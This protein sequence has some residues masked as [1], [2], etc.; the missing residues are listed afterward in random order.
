MFSRYIETMYPEDVNNDYPSL[1]CKHLFDSFLKSYSG[2]KVN[3]L[4]IGSGRGTHL[5]NF[6]SH[7]EGNF[8]G[9][10][11]EKTEIPG[12]SIQS[13]NLEND[14]LPYDDGFFD[15]VFSKSVIEHVKNTDNFMKEI[16]RVLKPGG[17]LILMAPDWQ[18][19]MKNFYDD[20]THVRPFT[21]KSFE[22]LLNVYNFDNAQVLLFRQLPA[23]WK[24]PALEYFCDIIAFVFPESFKWKSSTGRNTNDRKIIRFSK[25]KMLIGV[26][27]K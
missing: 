23:V 18:S 6:R 24:Y 15:I 8:H 2:K 22:S 21:K 12:A 16:Y 17:I 10:D 25:E 4:D 9:I 11:L 1:L 3:F 13:C 26:G 19:Q 5:N 27:I 7:L 20:F 14:S